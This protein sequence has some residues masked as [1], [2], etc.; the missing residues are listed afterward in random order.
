MYQVQEE[1][2]TAIQRS[3]SCSDAFV[4]LPLEAAQFALEQ[5]Q[6]LFAMKANN[7]H[8]AV[9]RDKAIKDLDISDVCLKRLEDDYRS[10]TEEIELLNVE[11]RR[12]VHI[13]MLMKNSANTSTTH[14]RRVLR[15]IASIELV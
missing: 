11:I 2:Q 3:E 12:L 1:L 15:F 4:V 6:L 8:L 14:P 5:L 13:I 10:A 9:E 7:R